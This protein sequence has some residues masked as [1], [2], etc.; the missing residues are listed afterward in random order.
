MQ[1][2]LASLN[3]SSRT[4]H[5][6]VDPVLYRSEFVAYGCHA[7][8]RGSW[9]GNISIIQKASEYGASDPRGGMSMYAE[10]HHSV[11]L[12]WGSPIPAPTKGDYHGISKIA[13]GNR[14]PNLI[15]YCYDI[16]HVDLLG[17]FQ[18]GE[19]TGVGATEG[20]VRLIISFVTCSL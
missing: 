6:Y 12:L 3:C 10:A 5:F 16:V 13:E 7:M 19:A 15:T 18:A 20:S 1:P 4:L 14:R 2:T 17:W 11:W 9:S 8:H